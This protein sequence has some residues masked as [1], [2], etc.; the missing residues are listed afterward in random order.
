MKKIVFI[1]LIFLLVSAFTTEQKLSDAKKE[2]LANE[3]FSE[4]KCIICEGQSIADSEADLAIDL[5]ALVRK[6]VSEGKTKNEIIDFV[7]ARY[8]QQILLKPPLNLST[9]ILWY[10]PFIFLM[11]GTAFIFLKRSRK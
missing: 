8:G 9:Y 1:F 3:I 11:L 4:L 7:A 5:R 2:A 6:M 10:S